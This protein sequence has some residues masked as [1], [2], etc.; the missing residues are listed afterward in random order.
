MKAAVSSQ[1]FS[2]HEPSII[3]QP[4]SS[5]ACSGLPQ[6]SVILVNA[7]NIIRT[8]AKAILHFK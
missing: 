1:C 8:L 7:A 4:R 2:E 6:L 5:G 3:P